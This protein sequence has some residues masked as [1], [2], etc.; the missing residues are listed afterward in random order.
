MYIYVYRY[1]DISYLSIYV[2]KLIQKT[3]ATFAAF[4]FPSTLSLTFREIL[5]ECL[6]AAA[7]ADIPFTPPKIFFLFIYL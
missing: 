3:P 5:M 4:I 2:S 1:I 7:A 6:A